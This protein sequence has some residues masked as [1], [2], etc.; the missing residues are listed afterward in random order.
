MILKNTGDNIKTMVHEKDEKD[1]VIEALF[2]RAKDYA[3]TRG[4]LFRLKAIKKTSEVGSSLI[5]NVI[6]GFL[7]STFLIMFN[8]GIAFWLGDIFGATHYGFFALAG[9]Y[10]IVGIIIYANRKKLLKSKIANSIIKKIND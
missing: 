5:S 8:I 1:S 6:I 10:L 7:F 4:D 9:F 2:E 3:E